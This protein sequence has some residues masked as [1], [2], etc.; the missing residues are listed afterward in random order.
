VLSDQHAGS[1]TSPMMTKAAP[2]EWNSRRLKISYSRSVAV[3]S[4]SIVALSCRCS[5]YQP[6][7]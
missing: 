6:L 4:E 7:V 3:R 2:H 5:I 1:I